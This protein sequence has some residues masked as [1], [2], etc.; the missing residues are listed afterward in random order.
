MRELYYHN[1][2]RWFEFSMV[3]LEADKVSVTFNEITQQKL[4]LI[5]IEHQHQ[6]HG[7]VFTTRTHPH[8][9]AIIFFKPQFQG[10]FHQPFMQ[11]Q[12]HFSKHLINASVTV[13]VT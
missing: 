13:S 1:L 4:A 8:I 7:F 9:N 12:L 5:E 3:K 11:R 10:H 2:R 6:L